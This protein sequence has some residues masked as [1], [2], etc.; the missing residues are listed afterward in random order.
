LKYPYLLNDSHISL[1]RRITGLINE[2]KSDND[3]QD[4]GPIVPLL[5]SDPVAL[6][7]RIML[8]LPYS[9]TKGTGYLE[10][11]LGEILSRLRILSSDCTSS[12]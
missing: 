8:S 3:N 2:E 12:I 1:W 5:L 11:H 4:K 10:N 7:L 6:L 9:I